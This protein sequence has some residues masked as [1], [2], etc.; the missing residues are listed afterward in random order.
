MPSAPKIS[1]HPQKQNGIEEDGVC[2]RR[3]YVEN[4]ANSQPD[5]P[6]LSCSERQS[7]LRSLSESQSMSERAGVGVEMW[8][9]GSAQGGKGSHSVQ[10]REGGSQPNS[11]SAHRVG[12]Q[13]CRRVLGH[14]TDEPFVGLCRTARSMRAGCASRSS[15]FSNAIPLISMLRHAAVLLELH[16]VRS[17]WRIV[18]WHQQNGEACPRGGLRLVR[19]NTTHDQP[20]AVP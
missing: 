16:V 13:P 3:I 2:I 19:T 8:V 4:I 18:G 7:H 11:A 1:W 12:H 10:V 17:G 20:V 6:V 14:V 15:P 9:E 5:P